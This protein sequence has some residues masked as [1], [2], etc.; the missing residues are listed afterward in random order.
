[1]NLTE[2]LCV[3]VFNHPIAAVAAAATTTTTLILYSAANHRCSCTLYKSH[4]NY[5]IKSLC[6]KTDK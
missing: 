5:K 1:M 3:F 6:R 4:K 2:I